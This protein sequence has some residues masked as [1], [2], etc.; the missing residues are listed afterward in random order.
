MGPNSLS[1]KKFFGNFW[2]EQKDMMVPFLG[3]GGGGGHGGVG[4]LD[5]PVKW[6]S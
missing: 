6:Y 3:F 2:G 4:L 5:P 1:K